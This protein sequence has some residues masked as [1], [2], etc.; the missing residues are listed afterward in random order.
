VPLDHTLSVQVQA[1]QTTSRGPDRLQAN[2]V[3][4]LSEAGYAILPISRQQRLLPGEARF[5]FVGVPPL[6]G[7]L[8]GAQ[9]VAYAD[10]V[11]GAGRGMPDSF[12]GLFATSDSSQPIQLDNFLEVPLLEH[13]QVGTRWDGR[14]LKVSWAP[15]GV[16]VDLLVFDIQSAGGLI[17]WMVA[18]PGHR[19]D[20]ELPDLRA[21]SSE[22]GLA[23]GTLSIRVSVAQKIGR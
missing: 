21:L 17:N 22:L 2:V 19:R 1:P 12:G 20:I 11:T 18:A 3:V 16:P 8:A 10:A 9:Y 6:V 23:R 13:P 14:E 4:R 5:D 15:G 7:S